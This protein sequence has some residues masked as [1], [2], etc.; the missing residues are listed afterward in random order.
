MQP[1][2]MLDRVE[3]YLFVLQYIIVVFDMDMM[4]EDVQIELDDEAKFIYRR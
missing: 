3:E 4:R 1:K 2:Q